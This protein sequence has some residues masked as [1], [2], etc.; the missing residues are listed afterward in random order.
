MTGPIVTIPDTTA[1]AI[2]VSEGPP[3][4]TG[5][6]GSGANTALK[7]RAPL[8]T[9]DNTQGYVAGQLWFNENNG[10]V[11]LALSVATNAAVWQNVLAPPYLPESGGS[12]S[13]P[14]ALS[15]LQANAAEHSNGDTL[16]A[17]DFVCIPFPSSYPS[18]GMTWTVPNATPGFGRNWYI[19]ADPDGVVTGPIKVIAGAGATINGSSSA[20]VAVSSAY[21]VALLVSDGA[22]GYTIAP[23]GVGSVASV[24]SRTGAVTA[25]TGDYT[26]SQVTGAAPLASPTFTGTPV[27]P[28]PSAGDD[29]TKIATTAYVDIQPINSQTL[30]TGSTVTLTAAQCLRYFH[31]FTCTTA[32]IV[33]TA[34]HLQ[35]QNLYVKNLA[36]STANVT[37]EDNSGNSL[38]VLAPGMAVMLIDDG[39]NWNIG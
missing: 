24:F 37:L 3:G 17:T 9:D 36:A 2:Q 12:M 29:S 35:G 16:A 38:I 18:G 19:I 23:I 4:P 32:T 7:T 6:A 28:T 33:K 39:T 20:Q 10:F 30:S 31:F 11:Y 5:P 21:G 8:S 27:A 26:V 14:I 25:Q 13:G 15:G 1:I 34:T 22:G